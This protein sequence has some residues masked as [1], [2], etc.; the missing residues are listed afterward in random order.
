MKKSILSIGKVLNKAAQKEIN[1]G[2]HNSGPNCRCFC[3][4]DREERVSNSCNS[5]C[6][7]GDIPG[8]YEGTPTS[9]FTGS[10]Y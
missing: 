9:C 8:V 4:N 7:D 6:P 10:L 2:G 3:H 1:G 5:L